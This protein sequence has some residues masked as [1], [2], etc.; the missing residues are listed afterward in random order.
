MQVAGGTVA[1]LLGPN[2]A[3][4]STV[5][6]VAAGLLDLAAGR[7]RV[8]GHDIGAL[9]RRKAARVVALVPQTEVAAV[10]FR[11]R[12]VVAMGRAPHQ[13][14]WM[15]ERSEDR[16]AVDDAIARCDLGALVARRV[17]TLS[18]GEQR[19]V[20]IARALATR[21]RLLLLDEPG[22]FLDVRH[23]LELYE[24]LADVASRDGIG[25]L[26]A[27]HDLDSAARVARTACF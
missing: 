20:A 12:E 24:L 25:C 1:A 17:E 10:G 4:K 3:G 26:V 11:V 15:T 16:A 23:R 7:A 14:G 22:A 2:G 18:G 8:L 9:P 6:R 13:G 5:L 21:P 27:M 19:R